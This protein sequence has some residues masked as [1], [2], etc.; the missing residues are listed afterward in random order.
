MIKCY[1]VR[2]DGTWHDGFESLQE[3][4]TWAKENSQGFYEILSYEVPK[5][6]DTVRTPPPDSAF[7]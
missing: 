5:E 1:T 7:Q 3:A 6:R 2:C 4:E